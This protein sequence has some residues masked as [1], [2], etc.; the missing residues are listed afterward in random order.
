MQYVNMLSAHTSYWYNPDLIRMLCMEI[1]RRPGKG[2]TL[3]GM[4]AVKATRR[5]GAGR[6]EV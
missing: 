3:A 2:H 5:V 1:G 4:R 6:R